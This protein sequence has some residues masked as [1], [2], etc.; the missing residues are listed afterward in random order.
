MLIEP[1]KDKKSKSTL[2]GLSSSSVKELP[3]PIRGGSPLPG[4]GGGKVPLL[5]IFD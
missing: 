5:L 2:G 3:G 4:L 1:K